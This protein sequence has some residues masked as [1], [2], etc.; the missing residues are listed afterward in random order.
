[1]KKSTLL[2]TAFA[3]VIINS[4]FDFGNDPEKQNFRKMTV[5]F[6]DFQGGNKNIF[7][8]EELTKNDRGWLVSHF[9]YN[10]AGQLIAPSH[11]FVYDNN[12]NIKERKDITFDK[13]K[14]KDVTVSTLYINSFE[15]E[16]LK[17]TIV[18]NKDNVA[19]NDTIFYIRDNAGNLIEKK[20]RC[21]GTGI[22]EFFDADARLE[23]SVS[24]VKGK[25]VITKLYEYNSNGLSSITGTSAGGKEIEKYTWEFNDKGKL[26]KENRTFEDATK[27]FSAT[28][29]YNTKAQMSGEERVDKGVKNLFVYEYDDKG[30]ISKIS[31]KNEKAIRNNERTY[32]Y[33]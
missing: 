11:S 16:K 28:Y 25:L 15:K 9:Y 23:K 17:K 22:S 19:K 14:N 10:D 2:L 5:S 24:F 6:R 31:M 21:N 29:T 3:L 1:M 32:V 13:A 26:I 7:K 12:G 33:E 30:M 20:T 8:L 4:A 18:T 27:N